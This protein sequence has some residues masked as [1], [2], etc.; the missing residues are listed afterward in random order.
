MSKNQPFIPGDRTTDKLED[1]IY[2]YIHMYIKQ[3]KQSE[4]C[5]IQVKIRYKIS[6]G[7]RVLKAIKLKWHMGAAVNSKA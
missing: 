5:Y 3:F 4:S 7:T 1:H 2:I 6:K